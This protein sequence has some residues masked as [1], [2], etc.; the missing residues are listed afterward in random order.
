M[1]RGRCRDLRLDPRHACPCSLARSGP[2]AHSL[3]FSRV[4]VCVITGFVFRRRNTCAVVA[5]AASPSPSVNAAGGYDYDLVII[6]AGVGGHGA[7]MHAV[8]MGMKVAIVEGH[9]IGGT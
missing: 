8:D 5:S 6:G 3:I 7:A 9:D 1:R 4:S 2:L